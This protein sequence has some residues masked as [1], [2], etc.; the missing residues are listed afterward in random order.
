M[1]RPL[2]LLLGTGAALGLNFPLGKLAM[3]AGV[4]AAQWA[5]MISLGAGLAMLIFSIVLAFFPEGSLQSLWRG[6]SSQWEIDQLKAALEYASLTLVLIVAAIITA[7]AKG[8]SLPVL[9]RLALHAESGG[10][11]GSES[12][13]AAPSFAPAAH[14]G[15]HTKI[16][17]QNLNKSWSN[18][19]SAKHCLIKP[20]QNF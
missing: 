7:W 20:E 1:N 17:L 13:T 10:T 5:A 16:E 6:G 2:L 9:R 15:P 11:I 12:A 18:C 4:D 19:S 14:T 3:V 8:A